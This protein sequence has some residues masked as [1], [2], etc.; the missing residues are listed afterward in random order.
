MATQHF[1]FPSQHKLKSNGE[2]EEGKN[3]EKG[4]KKTGRIKKGERNNKQQS[5]GRHDVTYSEKYQHG[6]AVRDDPSRVFDVSHQREYFHHL[7]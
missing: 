6:G 1:I 3:K 2:E 7:I 4:R 5:K